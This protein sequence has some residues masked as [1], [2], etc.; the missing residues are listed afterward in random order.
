MRIER[1]RTGGFDDAQFRES[2]EVLGP[3]ITLELIR[4]SIT[5]KCIDA[6]GE[7]WFERYGPLLA[8]Q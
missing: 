4:E 8:Y 5:A 3:Q 2:V 1:G 7:G 6:I